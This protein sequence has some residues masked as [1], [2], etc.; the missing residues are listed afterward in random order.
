[1]RF[2]TARVTSLRWALCRFPSIANTVVRGFRARR[3]ALAA[4]EQR[5]FPARVALLGLRLFGILLLLAALG[6]IVTLSLFMLRKG[7]S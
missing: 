6:G 7:V 3:Q 5:P 1:M 2:A 4:R